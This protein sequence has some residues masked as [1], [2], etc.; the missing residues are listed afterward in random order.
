V[1]KGIA[2]NLGGFVVVA[3]VGASEAVVFDT[4]SMGPAVIDFDPPGGPILCATGGLAV[5]CAAVVSVASLESF[6][7]EVVWSRRNLM[8]AMSVFVVVVL[9]SASVAASMVLFVTSWPRIDL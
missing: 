3:F 7:T 4:V 1:S 2:K 6:L 5:C 9:S 8:L